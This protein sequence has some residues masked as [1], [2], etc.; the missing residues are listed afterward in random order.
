MTRFILH[1]GATNL[2]V[3]SNRE[4]FKVSVPSLNK[5]IKVLIIYFARKKEDYPWMFE[6]DVNNFKTNSPKKDLEFVIAD[7]NIGLLKKQISDSDVIYVRGGNT[8]PLVKK[9]KQVG[10]L[11]KLLENKVYAGSS[12]GMY[13][14]AKYYYSN[15]R[16]RIEKG[17]SILPIKAFAHWED[18]KQEIINKLDAYK[19]KLPI[20]KVRE[21]EFVIIE[22]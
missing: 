22:Q 21:G 12:A 2:P 18:A 1:G 13:A 14:I 5:K 8:I 20:Y 10:D 9:L 3:E 16:N 17:L 6:Q 19:E 4:F 11:K 7:D 15:D